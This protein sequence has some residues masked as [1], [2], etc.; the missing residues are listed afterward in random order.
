M[1]TDVNSTFLEAVTSG[2]VETGVGSTFMEVVTAADGN[3]T[4]I[5]NTFM[6]VVVTTNPVI[7][8]PTF[9]EWQWQWPSSW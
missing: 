3:G 5:R 8:S 4:R 6:E 9:L 2:A 7:P 1:P